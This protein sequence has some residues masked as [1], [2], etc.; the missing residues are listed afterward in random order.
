MN[1]TLPALAPNHE[2]SPAG[3]TALVLNSPPGSW[4]LCPMDANPHA[5]H[6][7]QCLQASLGLTVNHQLIILPSAAMNCVLWISS[8]E[9]L[10]KT[11]KASQV[12]GAQASICSALCLTKMTTGVHVFHRYVGRTN[13]KM[14]R[15]GGKDPNV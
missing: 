15:G 9:T 12:V 1:P 7:K 11:T 2:V 13:R 3:E 10:D 6:S 4:S 5:T 8:L 14:R